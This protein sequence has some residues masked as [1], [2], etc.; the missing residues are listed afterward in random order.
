LEDTPALDAALME[1]PLILH[2]GGPFYRT[3]RAV[4]DACLRTRRHYLDVTGEIA[5][6]EGLAAL[7]PAA[8]EAGVMLLPGVG[9][10]VVPSDCLAAY[11]KSRLPDATHCL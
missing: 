11:L 4:A 5:V 8:Q 6:F 7:G 1:V 9:F 2:A 10:D 3:Y